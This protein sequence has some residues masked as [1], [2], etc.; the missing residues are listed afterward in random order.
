M[1]LWKLTLPQSLKC[2]GCGC[3]RGCTFANSILPDLVLPEK[4]E[5]LGTY[6]FGN[7]MIHSVTFPRDSGSLLWIGARQFKGT[8]SGRE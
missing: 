8:R 3:G 4:L 2:I 5:L 7:S 6:V 1:V